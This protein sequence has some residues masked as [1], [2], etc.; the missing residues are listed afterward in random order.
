MLI[1][2]FTLGHLIYLYYYSLVIKFKKKYMHQENVNLI[3]YL[4][5][6]ASSKLLAEAIVQLFAILCNHCYFTFF[7]TAP[8]S[9]RWWKPSSNSYNQKEILKLLWG[10]GNMW[11]LLFFP[12]PLTYIIKTLVSLFE[13]SLW[14]TCPYSWNVFGIFCLCTIQILLKHEK[15]WAATSKGKWWHAK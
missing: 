14:E 1:T 12:E 7:C 8:V 10:T 13:L 4:Q 5:D 6:S 15:K 9:P 11:M 2:F 3:L